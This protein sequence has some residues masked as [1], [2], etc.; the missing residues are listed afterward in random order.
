MPTPRG[1]RAIGERARTTKNQRERKNGAPRRNK[2][3]IH[4]FE[5]THLFER[6][7]SWCTHQCTQRL[8][9]IRRVA[10]R[11][12]IPTAFGGREAKGVAHK[13]AH[14]GDGSTSVTRTCWPKSHPGPVSRTARPRRCGCSEPSTAGTR[15]S[16]RRTSSG[17]SASAPSPPGPSRRTWDSQRRAGRCVRNQG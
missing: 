16:K 5:I 15:T 7:F 13:R 4:L 8:A 6:A 1:L 3:S 12:P 14:S 17:H 10:V 11:Q 2:H 9:A